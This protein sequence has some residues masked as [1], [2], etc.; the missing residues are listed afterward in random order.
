MNRIYGAGVSTEWVN[1]ADFNRSRVGQAYVN[2][3]GYMTGLLK[4]INEVPAA[5]DGINN[6][7]QRFGTP[8]VDAESHKP[9]FHALLIIGASGRSRGIC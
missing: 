8:Q 7:A 9:L 1:E 6:L 3:L 5:Y 2:Y 4:L